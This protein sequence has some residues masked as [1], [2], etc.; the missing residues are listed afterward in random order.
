MK[1]RFLLTG[2]KIVWMIVTEWLIPL[3]GVVF[4][5]RLCSMS[6]DILI[7]SSVELFPWDSTLMSAFQLAIL[8]TSWLRI[9]QR[10]FWQSTLWKFKFLQVINYLIYNLISSRF[11]LVKLRV[12]LLLLKL[13]VIWFD[14]KIAMLD[15]KSYNSAKFVKYIEW[16]LCWQLQCRLALPLQQ[17]VVTIIF[18]ESCG[19][20]YCSK[21]VCLWIS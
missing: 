15:Y 6:V 17:Q 11:N 8:V 16:C 4:W 10:Y 7:W 9:M 21:W 1:V 2:L 13:L 14:L 12:V 19:C 3:T 20:F 18:Y 5:V